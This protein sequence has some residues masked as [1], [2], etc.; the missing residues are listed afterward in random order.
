MGIAAVSAGQGRTVEIE[1]KESTNH[2]LILERAG[3]VLREI[4]A[5]L[6]H[7]SIP[8]ASIESYH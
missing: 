3:R 7:P 8:S 1:K 5:V 6:V 4:N 2:S